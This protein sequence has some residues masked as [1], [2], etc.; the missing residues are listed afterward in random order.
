[1]ATA[2]LFQVPTKTNGAALRR[3]EQQKFTKYGDAVA[4]GLAHLLTLATETGGRCNDTATEL[5][6]NLASYKAQHVPLA[7]RRSV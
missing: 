7:L 3:A 4:T 5:V 6:D 2:W 1:M